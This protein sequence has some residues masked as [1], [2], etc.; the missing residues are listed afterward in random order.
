MAL[1]VLHLED[2]PNDVELVRAALEEDGLP[3]EVTRVET[4]T[5]FVAALEKDFFDIILADY[6][7][8]S[9]D[10]LSAL[11]IAKEKRREIPF[12]CVSGTIGEELAIETLKS[13]A[14]D[15]VLK[16]RLYRIAPAVR[17]ALREAEDRSQRK[18][19]EEDL[20]KYREHLEELVE[21]RTA[22]LSEMNLHLDKEIRER[23]RVE[24][25][26]RVIAENVPALFSC[27]DKDGVYR[28]VNKRYE[29]WFGIPC[30]EIT[31]KPVK[32][33]IGE[34]AYEV[35]KDKAKAVLSGERITFEAAI[36]YKIGG[37]RWMYVTYVPDI[38]SKGNIKGFYSLASDITEKKQFEEELKRSNEDLEQ[39]AYSA[40]H[41]L[42]E[43]LRTVSGFIKLLQKRY[44]GRLDEKA[45][46]YIEYAVDGV[47]KMQRLI[48]DLLVYSRVGEDGRTFR[49]TNCSEVLDRALINLRSAIEEDKAEVTYDPLPTIMANDTQMI[50]LFQN[51]VGNSLKFR[52]SEPPRI[53]I[54]ADRK[55]GEWLFTVRDNG[56]GIDPHDADRIFVIFR[57]LH[58][59]KEYEG[60]GIGLSICKKI[61]EL[62]GGR[63]WVES[64]PGRGS[65]F[66]FI[67]PVA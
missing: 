18:K 11:T 19:A 2:D 43:P 37:T 9:F 25:E 62:H 55:D 24:R 57:R 58:T 1:R 15:Y 6:K 16:D 61:V 26:I 54:S 63:I 23:I 36:P 53:H 60:T 30:I 31:G 44:K 41:D 64:E 39:F 27:I 65:M 20:V 8:P 33:I 52:G 46:E 3:S 4:E 5:D 21:S 49:P 13:G 48:K 12:I 51:L 35:I 66:Y 10:G 42:K 29:D 67:I 22:E 7:L 17:R 34:P 50:R 59:A 56:I 32:D 47:S 14:T 45:D 38:D 40:S 28:F